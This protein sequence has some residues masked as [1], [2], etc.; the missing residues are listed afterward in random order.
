MSC[1]SERLIAYRDHELSSDGRSRVSAHLR[2]CPAC[3]AALEELEQ[4]GRLIA[5][6]LDVLEPSPEEMP[7][8]VGALASLQLRRASARDAAAR[9]PWGRVERSVASMLPRSTPLRRSVVWAAAAAL[10]LVALLGLA[11]VR[12]AAAEF[13][14]YFRVGDIR[15]VPIT[16]ARVEQLTAFEE[17]LDSGMLGEPQTLREATMPEAVAGTEAATDVAGFGVR[18]I[19]GLPEGVELAETRAAIGPHVKVAIERD[20]LAVALGAAGVVDVDLPEV[21]TITLDVDIPAMVEQRYWVGDAELQLIQLP[22]PV[23]TLS[24]GVSPDDLGE[25]YLQL[26]GLPPEEADRIAAGIDWTSTLVVPIPEDA[27]RY[28]DVSVGGV[29][30][31]LLQEM[32]SSAGQEQVLLWEDGGIVYALSSSGAASSASLLVR[33]AEALR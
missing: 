13:L 30:A 15:A 7:D 10:V 6:A 33:A 28:R 8:A 23:V 27:A 1:D 25:A 3:R 32:Y 16:G 18:E 14:S 5:S 21:E 19:A 9:S 2:S 20:L 4:R 11:P 29:P 26:L 12:H 17:M 22:S 31:L 24:D